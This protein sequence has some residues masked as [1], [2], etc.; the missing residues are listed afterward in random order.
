MFRGQPGQSAAQLVAGE[1]VSF[2]RH[3]KI[4]AF[5]ATQDLLPQMLV[6]TG[7]AK[8]NMR[9]NVVMAIALP[10]LLYVGAH[11][12]TTGVALAWIIG[13]P[14]VTIPLFFRH[15]LRILDMKAGDYLRAYVLEWS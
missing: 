2:S 1:L 3:H 7:H 12:G 13:Y 5:R 4:V 6:A 15:T 8:L 14:I 11:W 10:M 9:F